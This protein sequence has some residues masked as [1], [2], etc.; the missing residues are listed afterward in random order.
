MP[1]NRDILKEIENSLNFFDEIENN[2]IIEIK[3][4]KNTYTYET[5]VNIP[6]IQKK[7]NYIFGW[8]IF[9][10]KYIITSS[11]IF[12]IL[13]VTTNYSAYINIAK[14]YIL[15]GQVE[16]TTKWILNSV[17]ASNLKEK[18]SEQELE[19]NKKDESNEKLSIKKYKKDLDK[20]N[21]DLNIEITPYANRVIIPKIWRN[22]PLVDI[23]NKNIGWENEL[24]DIFMKEL[25]KWIIRYPGSSKPGEDWTS[26]IF[27]HSSNFPWMKWNY[28]DVFSTLDNVVYWD[29]VIVYYGQKKYTYKIRE[30]KVIHPWDVSVLERDHDRSEI[31]LMTCRPIGT[32]INRLIVTWELVEKED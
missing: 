5:F 6:E 14:S 16:S 17:E 28:N 23:K 25:E 24:N 7:H 11:L 3:E 10:W 8:F 20:E 29:E 30:K 27:W 22:V 26:F 21:I 31:T 12:G 32:T 1:E 2:E 13:L 18:V 19:E 9:L 15:K 4:S